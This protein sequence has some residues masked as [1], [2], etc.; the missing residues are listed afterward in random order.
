MNTPKVQRVRQTS[1]A[2]DACTPTR[3]YCGKRALTIVKKPVFVTMS[4]L[5]LKPWRLGYSYEKSTA[6]ITL[7]KGTGLSPSATESI[8]LLKQGNT[9]VL[10]SMTAAACALM[11]DAYSQ[12]AGC[13][14]VQG[15]DQVLNPVPHL[16]PSTIKPTANPEPCTPPEALHTQTH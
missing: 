2:R 9:V 10:A 14:M 11:Q 8:Q 1:E 13:G 15:L 6:G 3:H 5:A 7:A 4:H 16:K 12:G